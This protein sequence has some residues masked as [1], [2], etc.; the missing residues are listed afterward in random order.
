MKHVSI[1]GPLNTS[2]SEELISATVVANIRASRIRNIMYSR[3]AALNIGNVY[4]T[5]K[6]EVPILITW[7]I[8]PN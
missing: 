7:E 5:T 2:V 1:P 3:Q 4:F 6:Q 8:F